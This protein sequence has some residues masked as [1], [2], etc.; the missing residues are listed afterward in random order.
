MKP[1]SLTSV[2]GHCRNTIKDKNTVKLN[3]QNKDK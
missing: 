1:E 3:N 2:S